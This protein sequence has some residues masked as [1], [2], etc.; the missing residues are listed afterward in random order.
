MLKRKLLLQSIERKLILEYLVT[1]VVALL[2]SD[3]VI[4]L[5]VKDFSFIGLSAGLVLSVITSATCAY[6]M[7]RR[8]S[9]RIKALKNSLQILSDGGVPPR[10]NAV[11]TD[12]LSTSVRALNTLTERLDSAASFAESIG[13][14]ELQA[15]YNKKFE[16]D[17]LAH[18]LQR[19]HAQ[20]KTAADE[21]QRRGWVTTGLAN[22]AEILR[23]SQ[24]NISE[25]ANEIICNVVRYLKANQG[26]LFVLT[27]N[28]NE[29]FLELAATYAWDRK[30]HLKAKVVYGE[31]LVGQAWAERETIVLKEIPANY[32]RITSGLGEALPASV[33]IIPMKLDQQVF[34]ILEL[35]SFKNFEKHEIEFLEKLCE[36]IASALSAAKINERTRH[37]LAES[38]HQ[39]E[40]LRAQEEEMRQNMEELTATQEEMARKDIEM[41]GQLMAINNSMATIE[42]TM[43]GII[44]NANERFLTFTGYTMK[45]ILNKH[46]RM[47]CAD[48]YVKSD[49]YVRFWNNLGKGIAQTGEF[50]RHVKGG[51][52]VWISASYTVVTDS[53]GR[54]LKV[55]KFAMDITD[56]KMKALDFEGQINAVNHTMAAIEFALDGTIVNANNNFLETMGYESHEIINRHHRI[57]VDERESQSSGYK[58]F[59]EEL[60][61][62]RAQ[63][64]EFKRFGKNQKNVWIQATYTPIRNDEGTVYKVIKFALDVTADKLRAVDFEGQVEAIR[65]SNAVIEFDLDG[66]I[67]FAND[68]F[69]QALGYNTSAE[70]IGK[71]HSMFVPAFEV[72]SGEYKKFWISLKNK[73]HFTGEFRRQKAN[74]DSVWIYGS[75]NPILDVEGKAYKVVKYATIVDRQAQAVAGKAVNV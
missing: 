18:A 65:R 48:E 24:S 55:I 38:Q 59:W 70:L 75:Y 8:T 14:G 11:G 2:I 43:D 42:F 74:G 30:K 32:I 26:Q 40:E 7:A 10:M 37:L 46:H 56:Q 69:V 27:E 71:H 4:S 35:A 23:S 1:S 61:A 53:E 34:G 73:K 72:Q 58:R 44:T 15:R 64:G 41:S 52:K 45:E 31:G 67:L 63:S 50:K 5:T 21:Q 17:I 25:L 39:T 60:R 9:G 12:E 36:L 6:F 3:V 29:S 33:V 57:F 47:F 51:R 22:F 16:N 66:K 54:P 20:L 49:E 62:G 68:L 19:M 13:K 28:E